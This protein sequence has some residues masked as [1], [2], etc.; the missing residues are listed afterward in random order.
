MSGRSQR[1]R[2][3]SAQSGEASLGYGVPQGLVLGPILFSVYT[4]PIPNIMTHHDVSY[5]KFADDASLLTYYNPSVPGDL[6]A[7]RGEDR[8][9]NCFSEL[10][11]WMLTN[12]FAA[13]QNQNRISLHHVP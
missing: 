12:L 5:S 3:G 6:H 13:K 1:I 11:A 7:R 8:L 4:K 9:S 2:T 10:R